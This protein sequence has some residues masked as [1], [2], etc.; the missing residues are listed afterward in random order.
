MVQ[1]AFSGC[2][3]QVGTPGQTMWYARW[4]HP[5]LPSA[6]LHTPNPSCQ[7]LSLLYLELLAVQCAHLCL[8]GAP[9][10]HIVIFCSPWLI[11]FPSRFC[12]RPNL[13]GESALL[14]EIHRAYDWLRGKMVVMV[15]NWWGCRRSITLGNC[16]NY[17]NITWISCE[18]CNWI[19]AT[20]TDSPS[21]LQFLK[22]ANMF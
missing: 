8:Q 4:R 22:A 13:H 15:T 10:V 21:Y 6:C 1:L 14:W 5:A 17:K 12:L 16:V 18:Y 2:L 19:T 11:F 9:T 7:T 20:G 3:I